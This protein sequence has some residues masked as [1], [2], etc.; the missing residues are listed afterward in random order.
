MY[1]CVC[2]NNVCAGIK[3]DVIIYTGATDFET[4][5]KTP[6]NVLSYGRLGRQNDSYN[7]FMLT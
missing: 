3:I 2:K 6:K 1:T 4:N 7:Y 5:Q